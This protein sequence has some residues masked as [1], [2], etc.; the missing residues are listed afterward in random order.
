VKLPRGWPL[1]AI[2]AGAVAVAIYA[3]PNQNVAIAGAIAAL[4]ALGLFLL[5]PARRVAVAPR[6]PAPT[7]VVDAA[8]PFRASLRAGRAG[9]T[10]VV[11]LLDELERRSGHPDR[12]T[13]P[14]TEVA[15]LRGLTGTDFRAYVRTRLDEIESERS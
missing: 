1:L 10:E 13:T 14:A 5:G 2:A 3:G 7:P 4:V 6:S 9:R 12:P 8:T 15:R 11:V